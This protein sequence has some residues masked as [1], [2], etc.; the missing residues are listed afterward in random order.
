MPKGKEEQQRRIADTR[1][2]AA[3]AR[4]LGGEIGMYNTSGRSGQQIEEQFQK[5]GPQNRQALARSVV[6]THRGRGR[7]AAMSVPHR[8]DVFSGEF[9]GVEE[10]IEFE[11]AMDF[12]SA[13]MREQGGKGG[14]RLRGKSEYAMLLQA[15]EAYEGMA[16]DTK[17]QLTEKQG[18]LDKLSLA[19]SQWLQRHNAEE[20]GN[21]KEDE[22]KRIVAASRL[23]VHLQG[24]IKRVQHAK[25]NAPT[26]EEF[27]FSQELL[28]VEN[29][30]KGVMLER[31]QNGIVPFGAVRENNAGSTALSKAGSGLARE[32]IERTCGTQIANH[33]ARWKV[34]QNDPSNLNCYK[35]EP[36]SALGPARSFYL[37]K[38][39][40]INACIDD[41]FAALS[42]G[43]P[44]KL[45]QIMAAHIRG[46]DGYEIQSR[47]TTE[48]QDV[49]KLSYAAS[50]LMLRL[51]SP[52]IVAATVAAMKNAEAGNTS[53]PNDT[54]NASAKCVMGVI[55]TVANGSAEVKMA[56]RAAS[57][58]YT[59]QKMAAWLPLV[60]QQIM[61]LAQQR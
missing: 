32:F 22:S 36:A 20:G 19:T 27:A 9:E 12:N 56:E 49:P 54:V 45:L 50:G 5:A 17:D 3:I 8:T 23:H 47:E 46:M 25:K 4:K 30:M 44:P 24:E 29:A 6:A 18:V 15:F 51:L 21:G 2:K 52:Q 53:A 31:G 43:I 58:A 16:E 26:Q 48:V 34:M 11:E 40:L 38:Q 37:M 35:S 59:Q 1:R 61:A 55:Q 33:I 42:S 28:G 60:G 57:T 14:F 13:A 41:I 7:G 39:E 10:E